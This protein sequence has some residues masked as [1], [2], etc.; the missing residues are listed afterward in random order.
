[1]AFNRIFDVADSGTASA[2]SDDIVGRFRSGHQLSGRPIALTKWR[3][4]GADPVALATVQE[5]MGGDEEPAKW[6]TKSDEAYEVFTTAGA[7]EI[8]L[9]GPK[10]LKT[11][12]VL[13]GRKGK[14]RECDG[15]V[16]TDELHSECLCPSDLR[17]RKEGA[18]NGTACEPSI[19]I[20]F[21]LALN[22]EL[23]KFKFFTGSWSMAK[24]IWQ[25]EERLAEIDGPAYATLTLELVEFTTKDGKNVQYTKPVLEVHDAVED[26]EAPF[27]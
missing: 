19:Q 12:M 23:G 17:E 27:G 10:A 7:V 18:K 26:E 24:E 1:M 2:G 25:A 13:W 4:T 15:A 20:Y 14:I 22:P 16:Q 11:G 3:V 21:R 9:D 6:D 5:I 8:I